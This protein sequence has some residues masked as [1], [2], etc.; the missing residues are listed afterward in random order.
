MHDKWKILNHF[1]LAKYTKL[2]IYYKL[3]IFTFFFLDRVYSN[4]FLL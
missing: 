1:S 4:K 2:M 3:K